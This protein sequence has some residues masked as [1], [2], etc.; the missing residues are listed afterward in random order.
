MTDEQGQFRILQVVGDEIHRYRHLAARIRQR[1]KYLGRLLDHPARQ[2]PHEADA[3]EHLQNVRGRCTLL[4]IPVPAQQGLSP[5]Q[6][7]GRQFHLGLE[8]ELELAG[9][10]GAG[11]FRFESRIA[12][13]ACRGIGAVVI[14]GFAGG[15]G[16]NQGRTGRLN[17]AERV[18]RVFA[19]PRAT[20]ME[21]PALPGEVVAP[22]HLAGVNQ[23]APGQGDLRRMQKLGQDHR[24]LI[25]AKG[26]QDVIGPQH[27]PHG[28]GERQPQVVT[29][30]HAQNIYGAPPFDV[31]HQKPQD[32][33]FGKTG[34]ALRQQAQKAPPVGNAEN[35]IPVLGVQAEGMFVIDGDVRQQAAQAPAQAHQ[36]GQDVELKAMDHRPIA[37]QVLLAGCQQGLDGDERKLRHGSAQITL[38]P[39]LDDPG[40]PGRGEIPFGDPCQLDAECAQGRL[41]AQ[42]ALAEVE[43]RQQ[44]V[45]QLGSTDDAAKGAHRRLLALPDAVAQQKTRKG[46]LVNDRTGRTHQMRCRRIH[47]R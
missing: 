47:A 44:R 19:R 42:S 18:V 10:Q 3:F 38:G 12:V 35:R 9:F 33:P 43:A 40:R 29:F 4:A 26:A 16:R 39:Q 5:D 25:F 17:Q 34:Q 37:E 6:P 21:A 28:V 45:G 30:V 23:L 36:G 31:E 15:F 46:V 32:L 27:R 2:L 13:A 22:Q 1:G 20:R 41:H 11:H 14:K 7:A 24:P 8:E